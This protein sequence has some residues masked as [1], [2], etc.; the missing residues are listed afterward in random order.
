MS[1]DDFIKESNSLIIKENKNEDLVDP[2]TKIND[3]LFLGQGRTTAY[4]DILSTIGI[5]H[6]V[7]IGKTPHKS[8]I[9]GPFFKFELQG[10][11][12]ID[13]ENLAIHFPAIFEFM[14]KAINDGGKIFVHCEMG[15]SRA[16]TV[17]IAFLR[18]NGY[19]NSLQSAYDDVKRKRPWVAPN[20]GF[21]DQLR[22]FFKEKLSCA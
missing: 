16:A 20:T 13:K 17:M 14:R 15:C 7:S 1:V 6:V 12:D 8:V 11:L 22:K 4:A 19:Y 21:Q 2:I 9:N 18:A 3:L 10:A 5:T